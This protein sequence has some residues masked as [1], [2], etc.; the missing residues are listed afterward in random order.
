MFSLRVIWY[1][2]TLL[3]V[4]CSPNTTNIGKYHVSVK[5]STVSILPYWFLVLLVHDRPTLPCLRVFLCQFVPNLGGYFA[6]RTSQIRC[7]QLKRAIMI[8]HRK[9]NETLSY[10]SVLTVTGLQMCTTSAVCDSRG[11]EPRSLLR[12]TSLLVQVKETISPSQR[13]LVCQFQ[14]QCLR[15]FHIRLCL[16]LG[17]LEDFVWRE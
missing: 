11:V 7:L 13:C 6:R 12:R 1:M 15:N 9:K 3:Y 17:E 5:Q 10:L 16:Q 2:C 14:R 8:D 4:H